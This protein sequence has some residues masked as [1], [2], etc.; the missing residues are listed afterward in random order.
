MKY[1]TDCFSLYFEI[2]FYDKQGGDPNH[3]SLFAFQMYV[4]SGAGLRSE[5]G[6]RTVELETDLRE[7]I[8]F[9]IT[10]KAP[11]SA[12]TFQ[13]LLRQYAKQALTPR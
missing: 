12:F 10:E 5:E 4:L 3:A 11:T 7:N 6:V 9:T 13:T 1:L 2:T 8:S